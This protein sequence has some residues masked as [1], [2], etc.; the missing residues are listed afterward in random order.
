MHGEVR[1][2]LYNPT[3]TVLASVGMVVLR[4]GSELQAREVRAVRQH[5]GFTLVTFADCESMPAARELAGWEVCVRAEQLPAPAPNEVYHFELI[6]MAVVTTA[7]AEIGV[8]SD[9]LTTQANDICVVHAGAQEHLI[10]L[11][12]N[13][14]K[15]VDRQRRRLVI[16]PLPGLIEL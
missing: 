12:A 15:H 5:R 7:G 13:V 8:V 2:R 6:G 14:V 16:E 9:V 4:R 3:S 11:T 10:P 1:V